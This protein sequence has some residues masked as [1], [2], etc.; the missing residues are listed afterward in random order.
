MEVAGT[1]SLDPL[2]DGRTLAFGIGVEDMLKLR[3]RLPCAEV[4][5]LRRAESMIGTEIE[6]PP[7][8]PVGEARGYR[9]VSSEFPAVGNGASTAVGRAF[10]PAA[11][12]SSGVVPAIALLTP[13]ISELFGS[14]NRRRSYLVFRGSLGDLAKRNDYARLTGLA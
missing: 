10:M 3:V 14:E 8:S 5:E 13:E 1:G 6:E 4:V 7:D 11:S 2:K 12:E 9:P